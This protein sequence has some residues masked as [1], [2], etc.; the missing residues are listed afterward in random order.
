M[1]LLWQKGT[2]LSQGTETESAVYAVALPSEA[3]ASFVGICPQGQYPASP[4]TA[5]SACVR[6]AKRFVGS[7]SNRVIDVTETIAAMPQGVAHKNRLGS[8]A[9]RTRSLTHLI[10]G[11]S[12]HGNDGMTLEIGA[13]AMGA[14]S[15]KRFL[16]G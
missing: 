2:D 3:P 1:F 15:A 14:Y 5:T 16:Q 13:I 11:V 4:L 9:G 7:P 8:L 10:A 6:G 12:L